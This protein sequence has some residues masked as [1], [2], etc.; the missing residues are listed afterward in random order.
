MRIAIL[1]D[2][3]MPT[4]TPDGHGLGRM[5]SQVAEGLLAEGNDVV[6]FAAPG[7]QFSGAM[8][9][10]SA[11]SGYDG[12]QFLAREALK[13]HKE[14]PFDVFMDNGHLHILASM[15]PD[16]PVMNVYHDSFQEHRRNAILMSEGQK[17]QLPPAF[18]SAKVI[19]NA[20]PH[21][22][23]EPNYALNAHDPY[24]LF[25]GVLSDIKQ[26]V[27]AIEAC[28]RL[29]VKLVIAGSTAY[30]NYRFPVSDFTSA[31]WVGPVAGQ[32][33]MDLLKSARVFLQLGVA[34]SFGLTTLEAMLC[35]TP[36]VGWPAGGTLDQIYYGRNGIFVPLTGE[37]KVQ[38][39]ADAIERA[40][41]MSRREVRAITDEAS[42]SPLHQVK[43]YE[44]W[45]ARI[46]GGEVW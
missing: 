27:L 29:G 38:N 22:Q 3:V 32:Y 1:S 14:M 19:R 20:L 2:C 21:D 13:L 8:V 28:A 36:V 11:A 6:L 15:L 43:S 24:V 17:A 40:W 42:W 34:E 44:H 12:E 7:S 45:L 46:A 25:M 33:K 9:M 18:E 31:K 37:D 10:P 5:V 30:G 4:P 23:I 35:G 26:P 16:L 39:V 41:D